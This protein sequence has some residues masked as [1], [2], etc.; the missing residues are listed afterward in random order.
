V[1]IA[2]DDEGSDDE[3]DKPESGRRVKRLLDPKL[4]KEAEVKKPDTCLTEVGAP[5]A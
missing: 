4:P 3:R 5:T 2:S 1:K